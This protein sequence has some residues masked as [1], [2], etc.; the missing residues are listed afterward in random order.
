MRFTVV[1]V[2]FGKIRYV[3]RVR[4]DIKKTHLRMLIH[5]PPLLHVGI[6]AGLSCNW[7]YIIKIIPMDFSRC[8]FIGTACSVLVSE[9]CFFATTAGYVNLFS[10]I[11]LYWF[12][13]CV[14]L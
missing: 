12:I 13:D 3:L 5:L 4:I 8:I 9:R 1:K 11:M 14:P 6:A 10:A 7:L 2:H